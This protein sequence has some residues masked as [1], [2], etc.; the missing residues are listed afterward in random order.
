MTWPLATLIAGA[1]SA[2]VIFRCSRKLLLIGVPASV[3]TMWILDTV[4]YIIAAA[5]SSRALYVDAGGPA[6]MVRAHTISGMVTTFTIASVLPPT[7]PR[8]PLWVAAFVIVRLAATSANYISVLDVDPR[9]LAVSIPASILG[10]I[11]TAS[12]VRP[13][14]GEAGLCAVPHRSRS[15]QRVG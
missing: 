8:A 9:L 13:S 14:W 11:A 4:S 7:F 6:I 1:T 5:T 2:L 10:S 15:A 3:F 12:F